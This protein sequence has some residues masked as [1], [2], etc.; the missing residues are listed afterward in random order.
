MADAGL[1]A[2]RDQALA[3]SHGYR[4]ADR[5]RPVSA[6]LQAYAAMT[7]SAATGAARDVSQMATGAVA[8]PPGN[9]EGR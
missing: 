7:T 5:S 9:S 1:A 6:A 2:R 8:G 4:P 3:R